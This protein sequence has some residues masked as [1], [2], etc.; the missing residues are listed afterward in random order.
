MVR[1]YYETGKKIVR[2]VEEPVLSC[3]TLAY[4]CLFF[5]QA[6]AI[7]RNGS[8]LGV[9]ALHAAAETGHA[10]VVQMLIA[11]HSD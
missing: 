7:V 2:N 1:S 3:K 6:G 9:P 11:V 10:E 4:F 8:D 5:L